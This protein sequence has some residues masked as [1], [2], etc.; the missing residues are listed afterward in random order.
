MLR[1]VDRAAGEGN[2]GRDTRRG[3][4]VHDAHRLDGVRLV[5]GEA[6]ADRLVVGS[7]PPVARDQLHLES[8]LLRELR[9]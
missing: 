8:Q 4:V 5:L 1:L 3:L 7:A 9:P 6:L 2:A